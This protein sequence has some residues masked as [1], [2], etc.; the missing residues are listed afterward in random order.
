MK[1]HY[2]RFLFT[3]LLFIS[4]FNL[5][6]NA[7]WQKMVSPSGGYIQ[8]F[9][10]KDNIIYAG[11]AENGLFYSSDNGAQWNKISNSPGINIQ[12]LAIN[13]IWIFTTCDKGFFRSNNNG[14]TWESIQIGVSNRDVNSQNGIIYLNDQNGIYMSSD[15]GV[16]W[17]LYS[18]NQGAYGFSFSGNTVMAISG[19]ATAFVSNDQGNT[20]QSKHLPY[21][22]STTTGGVYNNKL[23]VGTWG[24]GAYVSSNG[25][26]SWQSVSIPLMPKN[27]YISYIGVNGNTLYVC[28][29]PDGIFAT[30]DNGVSWNK[31]SNGLNNLNF[32]SMCFSNN[33]IFAATYTGIYASTDNGLNWNSSDNGIKATTV[34][35]FAENKNKYFLGTNHGL[36]V[37]QDN[38]QSW[39]V[40]S[41]DLFYKS[42]K[43]FFV[44]N[45]NIYV[46]TIDGV[47][48]SSNNG[49]TWVKRGLSGND[50]YVYDFAKY[51]NS[52]L[53]ATNGGIYLTTNLGVSWTCMT[54]AWPDIHFNFMI[55]N[56]IIYTGGLAG[57]I[58]SEDGCK[59]WNGWTNLT[60][61]TSNSDIT[62]LASI[63]D[64][65]FANSSVSGLFVSNDKGINWTKKS[66]NSKSMTTCKDILFVGTSNGLFTS[67]DYGTNFNKSDTLTTSNI[68]I[69]ENYNDIVYT[70]ASSFDI[71]YNKISTGINSVEKKKL[72]FYPNPS[73]KQIVM[74]NIEN[75][76]CF[77]N[78]I[79][80]TGKV[81]ISTK[82]NGYNNT[83]NV[84]N[85]ANGFYV[86]EFTDN[87]GTKSTNKL[88][89]QHF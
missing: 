68:S 72:L 61:N 23:Y 87:F 67:S 22:V 20:W 59:S 63:N 32:N 66:I 4:V 47:F 51:G 8:C 46:G 39:K 65:Y 74:N 54:S 45:D 2:F 19:G 24:N 82:L 48:Y 34:T 55:D 11:T 62:L 73:D 25:G 7:Q 29:D 12:S 38:G 18:I 28:S 75:S 5:D 1:H 64:N 10:V 77:V 76:F 60:N 80:L 50:T 85:L 15:S 9:V 37:S 26:D 17:T 30:S 53:A 49:T 6:S 36:L 70:C 52:I 83:I 16:T 43:S 88:K 69:L 58:F 78:I 13:D 41:S 79:D 42:I 21:S 81:L 35:A 33:K 40:Q 3:T 89:I 31:L 57:A 27:G 71:W 84:S 86:I 14:I 56:G 44:D